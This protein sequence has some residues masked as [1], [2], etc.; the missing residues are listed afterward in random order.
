MVQIGSA[1]LNESGKTTGGKAGDQTGREVG[2]QAWYM[3]TKGWIVLRAKDPAAREKIAYAMAAAC[4]NEHIGYCQSH[5]TGATLAA[6]PYGYDPARIQ[7]DTET[8]CSEL[9]RLC[10]LYAGI[11]V[12]SFN[13][14][15]E[16]TMLEKTGHFAVYT[17][18]DHCN[19]PDRLLRGDILVTR[20]KGHTVVVLS[21]GAAAAQERATVPDAQLVKVTKAESAKAYSKAIAGTY[22]TITALHLR[23]GADKSKISLA[24]LPEGTAVKCY[25]YYTVTNGA[26]WLYVQASTKGVSKTGFCS[27]DY[28]ERT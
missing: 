6:E 24:V 18:G 2:V 11:K 28:L 25:G 17:D 3:H 5:R 19:G 9:V 10:C 26:R 21:D 13:T 14:A 27:G 12:P 7:Q 16:K 20:T 4:A 22:R 8:D 1:R 23:A 15:S